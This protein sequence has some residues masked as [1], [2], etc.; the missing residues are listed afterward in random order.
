[1]SV[2]N[3]RCSAHVHKYVSVRFLYSS[4]YGKYSVIS[5]DGFSNGLPPKRAGGRCGLAVLTSSHLSLV[6]SL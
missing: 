5:V 2:Q 1:M 6:S 3:D 4:A